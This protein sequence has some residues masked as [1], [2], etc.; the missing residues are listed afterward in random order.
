MLVGHPICV[1]YRATNNYNPRVPCPLLELPTVD[2]TQ[3]N[4]LSEINTCQFAAKCELGYHEVKA[5]LHNS[6]Y[7]I[8]TTMQNNRYLFS[9]G[10]QSFPKQSIIWMNAKSHHCIGS[11]LLPMPAAE[12]D[13]HLP[14]GVWDSPCASCILITKSQWMDSVVATRLPVSPN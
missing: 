7:L 5:K 10:R 3:P 12:N 14:N 13:V 9:V 2:H 4:H 8:P 6:S 1:S 11:P